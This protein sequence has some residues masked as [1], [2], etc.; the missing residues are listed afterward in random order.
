M[1]T[2]PYPGLRP[3]R[4]EEQGKFFGREA[5]AE[6]LIDKVLSNR[7]TLLFAASG[8]GKS[9]L[10]QAAVIPRLK[11]PTGENLSV[12][13][14][15]DWVSE[16]VSSVRTAVLQAL[17]TALPDDAA[18]DAGQTLAEVLEFCSLFVRPPLVLILDQFEEFFRYQ[19][20]ST[21]FQPFIE[22]LTAVITNPALAVSLVLSMRE[23]FALELNAF[24]PR[25]PTI[26]FENFYRLEK[27]GREGAREAI[28]TPAAQVGFRYEPALLDVLLNDLLSR[29]LDRVPN[30]P[31]VEW[32]E[33]VEPPYLQIVC[34]QLWALNQADPEQLLRL[35]TY[36]KAGK[37]KGILGNY[38]NGVLQGFTLAEK[39]LAS[40]AFDHLASQRGVK[41]AYTAQA[42]AETLRV[43]ETALSN[44]LGELAAVRI[45]RTQQRG[46]TTWYELFHDM[47]SGSIASW[48]GEW[49]DRMRRRKFAQVAAAGF[50]SIA[51][52]FAGWDYYLNATNY[53]LRM[54]PKQGISD[55]V[56]LWQGKPGSIDLFHQ[57]HYLAETDTTRHQLEPDKQFNQHPVADY[58]N[59]QTELVGSQPIDQRI[60]AYAES[61]QYQE[62]VALAK[63]AIVPEN[64]ELAKRALPHLGRMPVP[65]AA[66][67]VYA[68]LRH[69]TSDAIKKEIA[70]SGYK[71]NAVGSSVG[72]L[73]IQDDPAIKS[74]EG[75]EKEF[76]Q[77][78]LGA[79]VVTRL[80]RDQ[81]IASDI[82]N[83]SDFTNTPDVSQVI[84]YALGL[85]KD[86]NFSVRWRAAEVLGN[87]Q[88]PEAIPSLLDS[89]KNM[90]GDSLRR[91]AVDVLCKMQVQAAV[92]ALL[93]LLKDEDGLIRRRAV[94]ALGAMQAQTALPALLDLLR[95][96]DVDVRMS[97]GQ[98]L[99]AMQA[100]TALPALLDLLKDGDVGVRMSAVDV[101]GAMQ[102]Q[103]AIPALLDL[104]KDDDVHIRINAARAL[105]KM[106]VQAAVPALLDLLKAA[107]FA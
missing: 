44:V 95:D 100:Q 67:A 2:A 20:A 35:T 45:L 42:L 15:M 101:L 49:K 83:V 9:S 78:Q 32:L 27:L 91:E 64:V 3:Y 72:V 52:V 19:R 97:A 69:S 39:Q 59:L 92:P 71:A 65:E 103:T 75:R 14:H 68:I 29:E 80:A 99:G 23:D 53:H 38:L 12:V 106:Q 105:G 104:L 30:S 90:E 93:D 57:Q 5:D 85:L 56:E 47:F 51:A 16:P 54:S 87:M 74:V 4:E 21:H 55:Q 34:A 40:K 76:W 43:D 61:G 18:D 107:G 66:R 60:T 26:L 13:Y 6:I 33:T 88:V 1:S 37:A 28:V 48:N 89:L 11:S 24:K 10:L 81:L 86:E 84:P 31:A 73:L 22:Q 46:E 63:K 82:R 70:G 102:A 77:E 36:E 58:A 8:V 50:V 98:V 17:A 7:L 25:L 62:A 94:I 79:Q 96:G 41:M